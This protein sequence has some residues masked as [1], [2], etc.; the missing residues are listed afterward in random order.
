MEQITGNLQARD[1]RVA[2][3]ASRWN[4]FIVD[5]LVN[6]AR[7]CLGQHGVSEEAITLIKVPGAFELPLALDRAAATGRYDAL[8][9]LGAVIRGAT[10]HFDY[11]A[12]E[13]AR[14]VSRVALDHRIP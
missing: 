3:V 13:C 5:S 8:I 6:G 14:G 9:A 10:P 1:A 12:G 7:E 11:V 2:L 4:G